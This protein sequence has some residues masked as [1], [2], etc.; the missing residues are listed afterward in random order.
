MKR[1][2][3]KDLVLG[4]FF[5]SVF[6]LA[7]IWLAFKLDGFL[8]F[9]F[10][11]K[12]AGGGILALGIAGLILTA[13]LFLFLMR[14]RKKVPMTRITDNIST[15]VSYGEGQHGTARWLKKEEINKTFSSALIGSESENIMELKRR[16]SKR[17]VKEPLNLDSSRSKAG[18]VLGMEKVGRGGKTDKVYF[19]DDDIHTLWFGITG[20]G[21]TRSVILPSICMLGL[22]GESMVITDPKLELFYS[23]GDYLKNLG[24]DIICVDFK[25]PFMSDKYNFLQ[26]VIN[27]LKA[28]DIPAAES[29]AWDITN[30]LVGEGTHNEKIWEHG[31]KA[32]IAAGILSIV[33][34]NLDRPEYQN[35]SAVYW[36]VTLL[37]ADSSKGLAKEY[38]ESMPESHPAKAPLSISA[39][40]PARTKGSFDTSA[41]VTLRLFATNPIYAMTYKSE[42]DLESIGS[43]KT[44]V[45]IALPDEKETFYTIASLFVS[46]IY[47]A[48]VLASDKRGGRLERR[49]NFILDEF[50]NFAKIE[51]FSSKVTVSRG[52]GIRWNLV[53]QGIS[54]LNEVYGK[55]VAETIKSNC[56][57]WGYLKANDNETAGML[58]ERLGKYTTKAFSH[59]QKQAGSAG[60]DSYT[61]SVVERPL[62]TS[63]EISRLERPYT[64]IL[65]TT[66]PA[67]M[68]APF[69][70]DWQFNEMLGLGTQEEV[71]EDR[72]RRHSKR[73][74]KE[75]PRIDQGL[76]VEDHLT[77]MIKKWENNGA[78]GEEESE[79]SVESQ[80]KV[81]KNTKVL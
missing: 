65:G 61:A 25:N 69:F 64:L 35:L 12:G 57:I 44:A 33:F 22:V 1:L 29:S 72:F 67:I 6:V 32:V 77:R 14:D 47:E 60:E 71:S 48:L 17:Q 45:F 5:I 49:V 74:E 50:G 58:S 53:L 56:H 21:K 2:N 10:G 55:E 68:K 11:A 75:R 16:A 34:D 39:V 7:S 76:L 26:P 51:G 13:L 59:T 37:G 20:S 18:M 73:K 80:P 46:Q 3:K 9:R 70:Q 19:S 54:Q 8:K 81:Q 31:E 43:K 62:L 79:D 4:L 23:T 42:I 28:G 63:D 15:P 52:R 30:A 38:I 41:L 24:Y 78:G 36:L 40:A 27:A 66:Y